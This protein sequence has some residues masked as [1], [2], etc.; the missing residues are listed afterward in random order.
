MIATES[1]RELG[2]RNGLHLAVRPRAERDTGCVIRQPDSAELLPG[3][4]VER[5]QLWPDDR[6]YFLEVMRQGQGLAAE[7]GEIGRAH[8]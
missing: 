8:V 1:L 6:G 5:L 7:L 3:V 4:R 2:R